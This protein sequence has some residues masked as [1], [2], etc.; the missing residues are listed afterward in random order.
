MIQYV[1][2]VLGPLPHYMYIHFMST[3]VVNVPRSSL[4]LYH[5][6]ASVYYCEYKQ[7]II[8]WHFSYITVIFFNI[9]I[10]ISAPFLSG[11]GTKHFEQ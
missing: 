5:S 9:S 2:F 3:C 7:K 11:F 1:V 6:S 8:T 10:Q 4:L